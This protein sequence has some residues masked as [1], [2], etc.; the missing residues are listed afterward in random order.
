MRF[1][2]LGLSYIFQSSFLGFLLTCCFKI[3]SYLKNKARFYWMQTTHHPHSPPLPA[4][5]PKKKK[6]PSPTHTKKKG[7]KR[8]RRRFYC[9]H[10][11]WPYKKYMIPPSFENSK[12]KAKGKIKAIGLLNNIRVKSLSLSL[13]SVRY[14]FPILLVS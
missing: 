6:N 9:Q 3:I 12:T 1:N 8:R 13:L 11:A 4:P 14:S 2:L 7:K 10:Q 5:T